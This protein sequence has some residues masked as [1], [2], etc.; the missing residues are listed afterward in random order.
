[1]KILFKPQPKHPHHHHIWKSPYF[2]ISMDFCIYL[3]NTKVFVQTFLGGL[4]MAGKYPTYLQFG[5]MS[6]ILQFF[7]LYPLLI[8]HCSGDGIATMLVEHYFHHFGISVS[9][10]DGYHSLSNTY[11]LPSFLYCLC[12]KFN[13]LLGRGLENI[14]K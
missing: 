10:A 8:G 12:V 13:C 14:K 3:P 1:M 6:K 2:Q 7:L 11:Q 4:S 9:I 5:H